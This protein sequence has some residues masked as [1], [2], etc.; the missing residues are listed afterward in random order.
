MFKFKKIFKNVHIFIIFLLMIFIVLFII[1]L[2]KNA[3]PIIEDYVNLE[4]KKISIEVLRSTGL[5]ELN[6]IL[7]EDELYSIV[8]NNDGEIESVDFNVSQLNNA[9]II[10]SK[11]VKNRLEEI[12]EGKNLPKELYKNINNKK[13][14]KGIIFN[15][16]IGIATKNVFFASTGPK[17]P[18]K[19][20]YVGDVGV[21]VKTSVK[22][23]GL[24]SALIEAYIYVE[25]TQKA[26]MPFSSK[27]EKVVSKI[28]I[29][30]KIIKGNFSNYIG[31]NTSYDLQQK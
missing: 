19:I 20:E 1:I 21:D 14:K 3:S 25:V 18:V 26:I 22:Q 16:P 12:E 30:M 8:K 17:I 23:Y 15:V 24:N 28:P 11:N 29:I 6:N 31:S 13:L 5:K 10:V 4:M 7:K 9:L 2:N 27:E